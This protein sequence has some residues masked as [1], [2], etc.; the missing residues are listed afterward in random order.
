MVVIVTVAVMV[1]MVMVA[2]VVVVTVAVTVFWARRGLQ[3]YR[4]QR[5][6]PVETQVFGSEGRRRQGR[7]R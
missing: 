1:S 7:G 6:H 5:G 3:T 2:A 4:D